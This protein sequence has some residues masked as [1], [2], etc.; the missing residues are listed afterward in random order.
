[1]NNGFNIISDFE[2]ILCEF[3]ID[4]FN[5]CNNECNICFK[6]TISFYLLYIKQEK[7]IIKQDMESLNNLLSTK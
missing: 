2:K 7:N 5:D 6:K 1:M 4:K 3:R